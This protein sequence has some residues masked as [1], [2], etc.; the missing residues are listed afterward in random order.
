MKVLYQG[1]LKQGTPLPDLIK[2]VH[3]NHPKVEFVPYER[4]REGDVI[5]TLNRT[6]I[7]PEDINKKDEIIRKDIRRIVHIGSI[8]T[9]MKRGRNKY[10]DKISH[11]FYN[12]NFC[13]NIIQPTSDFKEFSSFLV[14][15]GMPADDNMSPIR[16]PRKINGNIH[17]IALA[18]WFKRPYKRL[19]QIIRL[20]N[21]FLIKEYPDSILNIV[22]FKKD[23][24]EGNIHYYRKSSH[25]KRL[26]SI[27]KNS[28]IQ[29][30][31]TPF[32]TGPKTLAE[33]LH[34]RVPFICSNNCAGKEYIK[35]LGKCGIEIETDIFIDTYS[36]YRIHQPISIIAKNKFYK[37]ALPYEKYFEAVK[38][39][40]N[41]FEEYTSWE[42]NEKL[43]YKDQSDKLYNILKG[44]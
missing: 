15:G 7:T 42:W 16:G 33:S 3:Y 38:E 35:I 34:Y 30:M 32:D 6:G 1:P 29:L 2:M 41:N 26:I 14:F 31:P 13:K 12:S 5:L 23:Y 44:K 36:K 19:P 11:V 4:G 20:Y 43:N 9:F 8:P 21:K 17:F 27:F 24:R 10:S 28:H 22:G 25:D 18:K 40:V 39:I 37:N